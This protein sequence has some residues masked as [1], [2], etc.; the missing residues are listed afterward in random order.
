LKGFGNFAL[1]VVGKVVG[2][3]HVAS[4]RCSMAGAARTVVARSGSTSEYF[5]LGG[6]WYSRHCR[7]MIAEVLLTLI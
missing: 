2:T 6:P 3:V 7:M 1:A 4:W 5:M